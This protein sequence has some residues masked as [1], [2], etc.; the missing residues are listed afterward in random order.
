MKILTGIFDVYEIYDKRDDFDIIDNLV[1][2]YFL[3][4]LEASS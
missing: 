1:G 3:V 2:M 4:S